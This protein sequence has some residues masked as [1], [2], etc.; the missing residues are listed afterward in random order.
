MIKLQKDKDG[1]VVAGISKNSKHHVIKVHRA[2][3]QAFLPNPNN[4]QQVNHK[5]ENKLNNCVINLEWCSN[6]YN[7]H[8]GTINQRISKSKTN[9]YGSK[10]VIQLTSDDNVVKVWPSMREAQRH[11]FYEGNVWSCCKGIYRQY[12]GY[13]WKYESEVN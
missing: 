10:R 11:G 5:D 7:H 8:Y 6:N 13:Q 9:G 4:Y 12:K 2:V 3:A 1:Y